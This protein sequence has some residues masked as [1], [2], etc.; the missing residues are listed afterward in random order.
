MSQK[1]SEI[2]EVRGERDSIISSFADIF[3]NHNDKFKYFFFFEN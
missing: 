3:K 1:N 2:T